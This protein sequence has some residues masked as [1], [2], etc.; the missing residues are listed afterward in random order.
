MSSAPLKCCWLKTNKKTVKGEKC[1]CFLILRQCC[2]CADFCSCGLNVFLRLVDKCPP[3]SHSD[4]HMRLLTD[5]SPAR[6]ASPPLTTKTCTTTRTSGTCESLA[7][8]PEKSST[9][10]FSFFLI[11]RLAS[12]SN[13]ISHFLLQQ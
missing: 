2:L 10:V 4:S 6:A 12:M 11:L 8:L 3:S 5:T 9:F 13:F 1:S 7:T